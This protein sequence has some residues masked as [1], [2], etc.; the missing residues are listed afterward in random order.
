MKAFNDDKELLDQF[1]LSRKLPAAG[2][3]DLV[4]NNLPESQ[5]L[6][7]ALKKP[8]ISKR[9]WALILAAISALAGVGIT[10][11]SDTSGS[12]YNNLIPTTFT[13]NLSSYSAFFSGQTMFYGTLVLLG[14]TGLLVLDRILN[15]RFTSR[16]N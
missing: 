16:N 12:S 5:P 6:P 4:M 7:E 15:S 9:A 13:E 14:I 2:L 1:K 11:S 3:A 10:L 8:L